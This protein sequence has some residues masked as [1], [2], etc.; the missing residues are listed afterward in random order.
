[1]FNNSLENSTEPL[2][3]TTRTELTSHVV[4]SVGLFEVVGTSER[5]KDGQLDLVQG[6]CNL[7]LGLDVFLASILTKA[8]I[9]IHFH[10]WI[11]FIL[12]R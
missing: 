4:R 2:I 8:P 3:Q 12:A 9:T 10:L 7:G 6:L 11:G 5:I 1:M